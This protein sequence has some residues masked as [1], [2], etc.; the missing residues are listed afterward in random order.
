MAGA[1][2]TS[3]RPDGWTSKS[4]RLSLFGV[5]DEQGLAVLAQRQGALVAEPS[6]AARAAGGEAAERRQLAQEASEGQDLVL[7][8]FVGC[9]EERALRRTAVGRRSV[10]RGREGEEQAEGGQA[11]RVE[12]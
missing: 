6:T 10:G 4:D 8:G 1:T 7:R 9:D 11:P 2:S 5:D 3:S 12:E